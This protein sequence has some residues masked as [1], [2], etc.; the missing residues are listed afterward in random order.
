MLKHVEALFSLNNANE[1]SQPP[2]LN[3]FEKWRQLQLLISMFPTL[4]EQRV[5]LPNNPRLMNRSK[6]QT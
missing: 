2:S 6:G 4:S 5:N 3:C 1:E